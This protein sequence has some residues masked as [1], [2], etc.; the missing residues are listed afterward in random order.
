LIKPS[1]RGF[2]KDSNVDTSYFAQEN[3]NDHIG[4]HDIAKEGSSWE[5]LNGGYICKFG[6]V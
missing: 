1:E 5:V 3:A 2:L 6:D 4:P